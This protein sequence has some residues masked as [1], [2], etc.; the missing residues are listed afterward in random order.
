M[1]VVEQDFHGNFLVNVAW[2]FGLFRWC[3]GLNC[4]HSGMVGK[5]SS[6][7]LVRGQSFP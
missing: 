2:F 7:E 5:I 3:P 4:A 1:W 6:A